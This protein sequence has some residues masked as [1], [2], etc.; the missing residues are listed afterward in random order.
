MFHLSLLQPR[1][2]VLFLNTTEKRAPEFTLGVLVRSILLIFLLFFRCSILCLYLQLCVGRPVS[3]L[4][5]L[6]LLAHMEWCSN[7]L[8]I[9]VIWRMSFKRKELLALRGR[10]GSPQFYCG[11]VLFIVLVFC[12]VFLVCLSS[13]CVWCN[14][15]C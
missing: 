13:F 5:Y 11:W 15:C 9:W 14:Q 12:V 3:Y 10:L 1:L 7:I 4:R 6:R 2:H 8:T